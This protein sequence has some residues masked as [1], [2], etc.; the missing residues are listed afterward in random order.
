MSS[1]GFNLLNLKDPKIR[2]LH[3]TWVAFFLSFVV[4]FSHAPLMSVIAEVMDLSSQQVKA[5]LILNVALTI[6]SRII[7]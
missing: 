1:S 5:L 4:W 3:V 2:M 7:V 6:L